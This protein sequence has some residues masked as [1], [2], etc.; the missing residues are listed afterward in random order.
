MYTSQP[1]FTLLFCPVHVSSG[2]EVVP[3]HVAAVAAAAATA[4][5]VAPI[6]VLPLRRWRRR[7]PALFHLQLGVLRLSACAS[8][9]DV[10]T[11]TAAFPS[12]S[13]RFLS[14]YSL[15]ASVRKF[16]HLAMRA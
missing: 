7:S 16:M 8:D 13:W 10:A 12:S 5:A 3:A 9:S 14:L 1:P 15:H 2:L 4:V 6:A 11:A